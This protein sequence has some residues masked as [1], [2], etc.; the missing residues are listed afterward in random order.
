MF[1][2]PKWSLPF[3]IFDFNFIRISH[4]YVRPT[5]PADLIVHE[6]I[7]LIIILFGESVNYEVH[8]C[9]VFSS[10]L[11]LPVCLVEIFSSASCSQAIKIY[12]HPLF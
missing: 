5:R 9:A 10:L 8:R 12:V 3:T 2:S 6:S 4:L 11:L 7:T 1:M